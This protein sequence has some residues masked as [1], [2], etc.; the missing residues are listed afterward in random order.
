M[1]VGKAAAGRL[2][3]DRRVRAVAAGGVEGAI[4]GAFLF[5]HALDDEIAGELDAEVAQE[6]GQHQ[7]EGV[8]ALHVVGAAA[9]HAVA[10]DGR[11]PRIVR[12]G[13]DRLR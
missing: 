5:D 2:S 1:G 6:T 10:D 9:V 8:A 13:R 3:D 7:V 12:P 4:A 11:L